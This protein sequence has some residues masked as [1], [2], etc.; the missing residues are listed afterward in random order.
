[1]SKSFSFSP[2]STQS[3]RR[4]SSASPLLQYYTSSSSTQASVGEISELRRADLERLGLTSSAS[5]SSLSEETT[6][7]LKELAQCTTL[8]CISKMHPR[9]KGTKFNLPHF[10]IAGWQKCATTSVYKHLTRHPEI[11]KPFVKEPHFFTACQR[12]GPACKVAGGNSEHAYIRDNLQIERAAASG[13]SVASLDASVDYAMFGDV[14]AP[15]FKELF[16]WLK[17]VFVMRERI[18]RA[19]SWKN[20]LAEKFD[21]GCKG[22]LARCLRGSLTKMN[23]SDPLSAWLEHF[24]AEQIYVMQFE[25]L[26]EDPEPELRRMKEFLGLDPALPEAELRNVNSRPGSSGWPMTREEYESLIEESRSDAVALIEVLEKHNL[27][28]GKTWMA[29]WE[30]VWNKNLKTCDSKGKCAIS[31]S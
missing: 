12:A 1:V 21:H 7:A 9:L 11:A 10:F 23:Y 16:P 24:P 14:L 18:G 8:E 20:M 6:A 28:N 15:K 4:R 26:A 22:N 30:A 27:G 2:H 13:L 29:K 5:S 25:A 19:M 3:H 31:S 17:I